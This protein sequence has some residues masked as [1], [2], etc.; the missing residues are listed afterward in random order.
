MVVVTI[1]FAPHGS[2]LV[3]RSPSMAKGSGSGSQVRFG[4]PDRGKE[5]ETRASAG[6]RC[7]HAGCSTLLT[8]YNPG[9][10]CWLHSDS[11]YVHPLA[12]S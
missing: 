4:T 9:T 2:Q 5:A 6:R 12:R 7:D 11:R 10:T 3:D 1:P 8:T